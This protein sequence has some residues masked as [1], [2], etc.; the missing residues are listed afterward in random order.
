[1]A[2]MFVPSW[3]LIA[4]EQ[5]YLNWLGRESFVISEFAL[6]DRLVNLFYISDGGN[7]WLWGANEFGQLGTE[8][9]FTMISKPCKLQI[10]EK[11]R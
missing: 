9:S 4:S 3:V 1:M 11:D 5:L 2:A 8:D 6:C 7:V 10:L